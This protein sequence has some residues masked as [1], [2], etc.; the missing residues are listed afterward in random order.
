[1]SNDSNNIIPDDEINFSSLGSK[2]LALTV[3]PFRILLE[4]FK[5]TALFVCAGIILSITLKY[6]LP[7]TYK[8]NFVIRPNER[9]ERTHLKMLEDVERLL[10]LK[11]YETLAR[12]LKIDVSTAESIKNLE[13]TNFA[14]SKSK[15]D[16]S[17]TTL[18]DIEIT[19]NKKLLTVQN[20]LLAYLENNAYFL[21]IKNYQKLNIS[22]KTDLI[23]KDLKLLDSL[24]RLQLNSYD[25][26]KINEQNSVFLKDLINPTSTYTLTL[27][28]LNQK[29]GLIAQT[30]FL[31]NF[32]LV[33]SVV[34]SEKHSWPPR[35]LLL[36]LVIVPVFLVFCLIYLHRKQAHLLKK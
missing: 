36:C 12:E 29:S 11:D 10:M 6:S 14:F 8:G 23:D 20:S 22:L 7:K 2:L 3:Y 24:K 5:T 9:N 21:K 25:K 19:D 1:M 26:I 18:I 35:I 17:N 33:K 13:I 34:V 32:Q 31:D 27:E 4:N 28:R 15:A 30:I 16:S